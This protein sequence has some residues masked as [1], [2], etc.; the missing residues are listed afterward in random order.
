MSADERAALLP[1]MAAAFALGIALGGALG[2]HP[3]ALALMAISAA[4]IIAL[5]ISARASSLATLAAVAFAFGILRAA[6]APAPD[7]ELTPHHGAGAVELRGTVAERASESGGAVHFLFSA[8]GIRPTPDSDWLPVSARVRATVSAASAPAADRDP[9]LARYGDRLIL[10]GELESPQPIDEFDYPAMLERQGIASVMAFPRV[11]LVSEDGGFPARAWLERARAALIGALERTV[12]EPAAA[13]GQAILLG[14]RDDLPDAL[15]DDFRR[16]GASH[17]LAISGLHIGIALVASTSAAALAFGRQ[18]RLYLL[19]PLAVVWLYALISGA[20]P[21]AIRAA[22]MGSVYIAAIALGRP[23]SLVPALA[24]AAALML[25]VEPRILHSV[26][27]QLSFAAMLGIGVYIERGADLL[28]RALRLRTDDRRAVAVAAR[29]VADAVGI[30]AAATL[31]TAPLVSFH[32]GQVSLVSVPTSLLALP[33]TPLA[34][35]AHAAAAAVGLV[36]DTAAAPFGWLAWAFSTYVIGVVSL[37]A[38][39]PF[40]SVSVGEDAPLTLASYGIM[41]A[42]ALALYSRAQWRGAPSTARRALGALSR[43]PSPW[44]AAAVAIAIA[45]LVWIAALEGSGGELE[46]VFAD[47]GQGD[48]TIITTPSGRIIVVDG[49]PDAALAA[50]E[51]GAKLPFWRRS[52][53]LLIL[54]HPHEDHI[55][56]L[57]ELLR[58]YRVERVLERRQRFDGAGYAAWRRLVEAEGAEIVSAAPGVRVEF[59]DGVSVETLAPPLAPLVGTGSDVDNASVVTRIA[60]GERSFLLAGDIFHEGEM[61]LVRS[62]ATLASDA[63]KVAHHGSASSSASEFLAAVSPS[64]AVIS[65]GRD[66]RFGHPAEETLE[67]LSAVLPPSRVYITAERGA[68]RFQTDG[69]TMRVYT[70]MP[71]PMTAQAGQ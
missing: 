1:P 57:S 5:T 2:A 51:L 28:H 4:L 44:Q 62:G 42:V 32:F 27:F 70:D 38:R 22:C 7:F 54:T 40:A 48:M 23:R 71:A 43:F 14:A 45:A 12:A 3:T 35:A 50:R 25:A 59:D 11:E 68:V 31:A 65:A 21:S 9:P 41:A 46:V 63:L 66:N 16:S 24:L 8:D 10:A 17:L 52:I 60:Y 69:K 36:S 61:W 29:G 6:L 55:A 18:R 13:F 34:L 30:T 20:S 47:V 33:A 64:A 26:S 53:D 39:L 15:E 58:R 56:G 19:A 37:M 67:R 49:G